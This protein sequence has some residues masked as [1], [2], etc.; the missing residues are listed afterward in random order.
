MTN[1]IVGKEYISKTD[2]DQIKKLEAI[3]S[4]TD[5][6]RL[7]LELDYKLAVSE[8]GE[9]TKGEINDFLYYA[10]GQLI[11]YLGIC[12][13]GGSEME[14][15]GM[16]LPE[17]RRKGVFTE[18]FKELEKEIQ[19]R[20]PT[21]VLLLN[22]SQSELGKTFIL[23]KKGAYNFSEYEMYLDSKEYISRKTDRGL[24]KL[25]EAI[26]ED[27]EEIRRQNAIYMNRKIEDV[28]I[29]YPEEEAKT[30][31]IIYLAE[32]DGK[33][34]GKTNI[35]VLDDEAGIYGLGIVPEFRGKGFGRDL[36]LESIKKCFDAG[37]AQVMLQV[38]VENIKA[39]GL[40]E[41][42]GFKTTSTMDYYEMITD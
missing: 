39:L 38:E 15:S 11:G 17:L 13:F 22:D 35:H 37:A 16:V 4:K 24:L 32:M 27:T 6:I 2:V 40:Y 42:V 28:E 30:G 8:S 10:E 20:K 9:K 3:C 19:K 12:S 14:V 29:T 36:L 41:S 5:G 18:L 33:I 31:F 26:N 21:K 1:N 25:K 7:K 34:I 23:N